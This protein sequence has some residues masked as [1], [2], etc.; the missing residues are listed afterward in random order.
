MFGNE[1][2]VALFWCVG[3]VKNCRAVGPKCPMLQIL[4]KQEMRI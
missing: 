4:S 3:P 2:P 1:D